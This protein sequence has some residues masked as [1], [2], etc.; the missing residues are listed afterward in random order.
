MIQIEQ[1]CKQFTLSCG[2]KHQAL[3]QVSLQVPAGSICGVIGPS[4]AGKSTLIRCVNALERVDSGRIFI[5]GED[6]LQCSAA[7]LRAQR[8]RMG[9]VFQHFN[10]MKRKTALQ[11]VASPLLLA[12]ESQGAATVKAHAML[13]R[14]G[15]ADRAQAYPATLSGGQRQRV[16][17]A[18]ALVLSPHILLC[19]EMTSALDPESTRQILQLL[20]ELQQE[21][22]LT[23]LLITHEMSVI[24]QVADHVV[25]MANG[26]VVESNSVEH[27]FRSPQHAVTQALVQEDAHCQLPE[28]LANVC[29]ADQVQHGFQL[30]ACTFSGAAAAQPLISAC[31]ARFGVSLNIL[32]A[33]LSTVH[34]CLMGK[35]ICAVPCG[36]ARESVCHFLR[37]AGLMIEE[38]GYVQHDDWC[39]T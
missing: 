7:E 11:N 27:I 15:L 1:L 9:M 24:K 21:M 23:V 10:L 5:A 2:A 13:A 29:V 20:S 26:A 37:D 28:E 35:M 8:R 17:I 18:R 33:N 31:A 22:Q 38:L 14:V 16:A 6:I 36:E 39:F 25:V 12:G 4:G 32:Q 34:G 3:D 30:L 19:D